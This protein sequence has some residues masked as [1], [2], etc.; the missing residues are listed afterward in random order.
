MKKNYKTLSALLAGICLFLSLAVNGQNLLGNGDFE[1]G[2]LDPWFG[3]NGSVVNIVTDAAQGTYAAVGN[4]AQNVNLVE[5]EEYELRCKG[6][7][8]SFTGDEKVW[9]GVRGPDASVQNQRIFES[10]W[11]DLLI[12]FTAPVT[13]THKVWIWGQGGS[14]YASDDWS[15]I[16]KG[17]ILSVNDQESVEKIK[18]RNSADGVL[19]NIANVVSESNIKVHD[20]A[21]R[22]LYNLTTSQGTALIEKNQFP[23][24]GLYII[25][26]KSDNMHRMEKVFIVEN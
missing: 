6:K 20:L 4:A 18:I 14:S 5:G 2:M 22:Q 9:I 13:G 25:T 7:I 21:G 19:I 26:V 24:T 8:I 23:S 1:T 17:T 15:L 16:V 3:D 12:E 10:T 11:E